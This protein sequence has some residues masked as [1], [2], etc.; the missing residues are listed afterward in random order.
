MKLKIKKYIKKEHLLNDGDKVI[1]GFSGGADSVA[2][3]Y[4]LHSIDFECIA[5]HCN[6][7]L[8][9]DE[10]ERDEQFA[11]AFAASLS[12]PFVKQDFDTVAIAKK[13]GV[14]IEMAARDLRYEWFEKLRKRHNA[15]TIA[16]AHHQ[17]DSIETLLL[18]L[19]RGTGIRGLTGIKPQAGNIIRPLLC[20]S[21]LEIL[22]FVTAKKLDFVTDSSNLQADFTRNKIRLQLIPL[23]ETI[24]PSAKEALLQTIYNLN[25]GAKIYDAEIGKAVLSVF[26]KEKNSIDIALLKTFPSPESVLFDLLK[27]YGFGKEVILDINRAID[28]H[29]GKEFYSDKYRLVRDRAK[30]LLTLREKEKEEQYLINK[31][32][33]FLEFPLRMELVYKENKQNFTIDKNK[34]VACLDLDKLQFPLI[35]RKWRTGDKFVPFGMNSFQKLSDFF[36]NNKFSKIEKENTWLLISENDIGWIINHRID[37]RF[38]VTKN[39]KTQLMIKIL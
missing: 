18:N 7:H 14:S 23:L 19:I 34:S 6:F 24:N 9:D 33:S 16:V 10:S 13:R 15:A 11:A 27:E 12:V 25:E 20:V 38:K 5:A 26:N 4:I 32:E 2:L 36:N 22:Q 28:S 39:T 1:V 29:S 37:N 8:R 35:L 17:D 30:F 31:G 3:L 21:K